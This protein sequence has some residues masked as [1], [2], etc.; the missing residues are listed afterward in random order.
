MNTEYAKYPVRHIEIMDSCLNASPRHCNSLCEQIMKEKVRFPWRGIFRPELLDSVMISYVRKAGCY[1]SS[2][3]AEAG[4]DKILRL[5]RKGYTTDQVKQAFKL[6]N[7][8]GL[9]THTIFMIGVPGETTRD[10]Q[11]TL[12]TMYKLKPDYAE[13]NLYGP[14]PG[15]ELYDLLVAK[16][17]FTPVEDYMQ[18]IGGASVS[19]NLKNL[20]SDVIK[21]TRSIAMLLYCSSP[22][23]L[24]KLGLKIIRDVTRYP[25]ISKIVVKHNF[26]KFVP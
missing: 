5:L 12:K 4:S 7:D 18:Y 3:G 9:E 23:F 10:L 20:P 16:K 8:A 6:T 26:R 19:L 17:I 22:I 15:C 2:I 1:I 14:L 24:K 21:R 13:I 25:E 11:F